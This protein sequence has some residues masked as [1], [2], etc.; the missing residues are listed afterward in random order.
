VRLESITLRRLE[1]PLERPY[2]LAFGTVEAFNTILVEVRG[3]DGGVGYGEAT[4]LTGYT[5]ET[6]EAA[7]GTVTAAAQAMAGSNGEAAKAGLVP[8]IAEHPFAATALVTAIEMLEGDAR[9]TVERK[10][11]VPLLAIVNA[12]HEAE[13]A[14][15][16][17]AR[18]AEGYRTLKIKVGFEAED[19]LARVRLIQRLVRGRAELRLDGNQGYGREAACRF[20]AALDPE[21]IE[22]FEQ[23]CPAVDWAAAVAVARVSAVPMM[24]DESIYG[25]AEIERAAE[26]GAAAFIKLKLMKLGGLARLAEALTRIRA[27]GMTPVLGNGVAGELG[28]WMEACVARGE[29]DNA[30]EMNG[31][32]KPRQGLFET[33]L[34]VARGALVLE[35]GRPRFDPEALEAASR[36]TV[37][38][39]P[40]VAA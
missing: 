35:P 25:L 36:E 16:I 29:I 3:E 1:L 12:K 22:L 8:L 17:E 4:V 5:E 30:G 38:I 21:G 27:C 18:L 24:L 13:L 40:C 20:A 26:L 11:A 39:P 19:D 2:R 28:C 14:P 32:L 6:P 9:L 10:T 31:F 34:R 37:H 7:W 23:P 15:E 33:P